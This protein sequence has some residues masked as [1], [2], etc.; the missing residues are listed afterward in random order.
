MS[1]ASKEALDGTRYARYISIAFGVFLLVWSVAGRRPLYERHGWWDGF[2]HF[3]P[4]VHATFGAVLLLPWKKIAA[5]PH[6]KKFLGLLG[7]MA[8][9]YAF[10]LI[11]E[12]MA[13]NYLAKDIGTKAKPPVIQSMM[14]FGALGQ[15][16]TF[17]FFRKPELLD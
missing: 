9:V 13:L 4:F 1:A 6:W 11:T 3:E 14:L 15:L 12:V 2:A 8:F 5:G 7:F 16:P 17:I 10:M